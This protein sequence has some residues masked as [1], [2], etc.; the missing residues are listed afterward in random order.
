MIVLS[1]FDGMACGYEAL[2]RAGI[3]VTKYY[4]SEIDKHA[5][6]IA[7]KNHPEIIHL[8]D[9]NVWQSWDIPTP[10]LIIG[11]SPCQGFSFAGKQLAFDDPRSRLFFTMC[12][13][14]EHYQP[15][16]KLLENV[17]M[18]KEHLEVITQ[19]MGCE[20][21]FI[22][23]ALVS[24]QN[25]QRYYWFN[26]DAPTP[27]DRGILLKDVLQDGYW[28]DREKSYCIDANYWKGGNLKNYIEKSRRQ[29]VFT[30]G[31]MVGR[32]INP[33]TGLRDD[34]NTDIKAEQR[35]EPRIDGKA[36]CITTVQKDSLCI[37]IG[38]A[39]INGHDYNRRVYSPE[40]K[41]PCLN[42]GGGG[43]LEPK[44]S[45]DEIHWRKLTP[46]ECERLQTLPDNYTEGVSNTQRYRM[47]GNGWTVDVIAHIFKHMGAR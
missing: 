28:C 15:R 39:D 20:P 45:L 27:E 32:R 38:D 6:Q 35:I 19:Y 42:A 16:F 43:N 21:I 3:N 24:A 9:V 1:L 13:I 18:K 44:T 26:W 25:R 22:N 33:E 41:A 40:G 14:I 47:L 46:I 31:R 17:K 30:G 37:R 34:Y 5:I 29:L 12:D 36:G 7:K 4:A 2:K 23:S 10:D 8:G 11:G